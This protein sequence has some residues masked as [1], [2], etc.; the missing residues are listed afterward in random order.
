MLGFKVKV[1][2]C[3]CECETRGEGGHGCGAIGSHRWWNCR[4]EER[5]CGGGKGQRDKWA[6]AR[7]EKGGS[8]K[9]KKKKR[10]LRERG[11]LTGDGGNSSG[12]RRPK[13]S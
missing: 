13:M 5:G 7:R 12:S 3:E 9:T 2:E 1:G 10:K 6:R 8:K 11:E 4:P